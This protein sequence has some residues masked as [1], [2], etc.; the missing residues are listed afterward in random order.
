M[1]AFLNSPLN[2]GSAMLD[3]VLE[4][5][6]IDRIALAIRFSDAHASGAH[7]FASKQERNFNFV[8]SAIANLMAAT[9]GP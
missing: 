8:E 4:R 6:V 5:R 3:V 9:K 1:S 2:W 7:Y